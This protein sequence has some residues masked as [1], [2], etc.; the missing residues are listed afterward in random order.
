VPFQVK[1]VDNC[2]DFTEVRLAAPVIY[3]MSPFITYVQTQ[4]SDESRPKERKDPV[5]GAPSFSA[6]SRFQKQTKNDSL[7]LLV[8]FCNGHILKH[9]KV[10]Y[11][12]T[13]VLQLDRARLPFYHS[14]LEH[15]RLVIVLSIRECYFTR[16]PPR[17]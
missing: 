8:V 14:Y 16:H 13:I 4:K 5:R 3:Y 11:I 7:E 9:N 10:A 6:L 17:Y 1:D 2:T 15:T 12:W